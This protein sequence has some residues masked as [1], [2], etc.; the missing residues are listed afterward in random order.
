MTTWNSLD[1]IDSSDHLYWGRPNT[2]GQRFANILL[3]QSDL[4]I[5]LGTRLGIQQT[6]FNW[7]EFAPLA[8]IIQVDVDKNELHKG[9]P[10]VELPVHNTTQSFLASL[11][12]RV[13]EINMNDL[14][15]WINFGKKVKDSLPLMDPSNK[16]SKGFVN[17]YFF[18]DELSKVLDSN[19]IIIPCSSGGAFTTTMQS[20]MQKAGQ[21]V[22]S[23]KGLASMGYGLSGAIGAAFA[24]PGRRTILI[25]GD[26]GFAQNIQELGTVRASNLPIK[27]FIY[28]NEGYASIKM[29]QLN[30]FEGSY[31]GCD[32]S[33]GLGMPTDW[34]KIF[35]AYSLK[36]MFLNPENLF[37]DET[38]KLL[39]SSEPV[40]FILPI[41]PDQTYF[42]KITSKVLENGQMVSNPL[43]LMSPSL[44]KEQEQSLLRYLEV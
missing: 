35:E 23:N 34:F 28:S 15:E 44:N 26:G 25:E 11:E 39:N 38:L 31:I 20:F 17:P 42:P 13:T 27:I 43:H 36:S 1:R 40:V 12:K 18:I 14:S 2:W 32:V 8:K 3:Q 21:K 4:I 29:T 37:S 33:T 9:H 24:N 7:K 6:G 30:Y 19:D 16:T 41:D 10:L 22:A 5:A